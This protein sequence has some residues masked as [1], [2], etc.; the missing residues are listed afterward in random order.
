MRLPSHAQNSYPFGRYQVIL[1]GD[2]GK[3]CVCIS[4][5]QVAIVGRA[6]GETQTRDLSITSLTM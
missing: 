5:L 1:L 4:G 2:S 3:I 6:V